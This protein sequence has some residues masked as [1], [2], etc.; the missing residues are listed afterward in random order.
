[1]LLHIIGSTSLRYAKSKLEVWDEEE[2][3][4][5]ILEHSDKKLKYVVRS[6]RYHLLWKNHFDIENITVLSVYDILQTRKF[7]SFGGVDNNGRP[8]L[9]F[10]AALHNPGEFNILHTYK[11]LVFW[12]NIVLESH[13]SHEIVFVED[14]KDFEKS[15]ADPRMVKYLLDL[16]N[17]HFPGRFGGLYCINAPWFYSALYLVVKPFIKNTLRDK[18]HISGDLG[19]YTKNVSPE[20]RLVEHGGN[21]E[22]NL[23]EWIESYCIQHDINIEW[24]QDPEQHDTHEIDMRLYITFSDPSVDKIIKESYKA[25]YLQKKGGYT[26]RT[27][28]R[29]CILYWGTLFIFKSSKSNEPN[30]TV[31]LIN[32]KT[33]WDQS[34]TF[35]IITATGKEAKFYAKN[36]REASEWVTSIS[37]HKHE[38]FD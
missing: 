29:Y 32:S 12:V 4:L 21:I 19:N 5:F 34:S 1:M 6:Y 33:L 13:D 23:D 24:L 2:L 9:L 26:P 15:S 11:L 37:A 28:K 20:N 3:I 31:P 27:N 16:F 38:I 14:L 18:I 7:F 10:K 25:G 17:H 8:I 30:G 22:F 36:K 35:I